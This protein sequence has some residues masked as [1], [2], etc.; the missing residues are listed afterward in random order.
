MVENLFHG[1]KLFRE[2]DCQTRW[3]QKINEHRI[4][5]KYHNSDSLSNNTFFSFK[6]ASNVIKDLCK[7]IES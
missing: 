3:M 4:R 7:C 1:P 6:L 2:M 5:D